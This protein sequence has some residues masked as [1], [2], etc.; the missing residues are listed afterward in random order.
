[1]GSDELASGGA[2]ACIA[3]AVAPS[4][5]RARPLS[6]RAARQTA[7]RGTL[8]IVGVSSTENSGPS[9]IRTFPRNE[10]FSRFCE[11]KIQF[12]FCTEHP[13]HFLT[14]RQTLRLSRIESTRLHERR[15]TLRFFRGDTNH[16]DADGVAR[17]S[18]TMASLSMSAAS[19]S[20][21]ANVADAQR[22]PRVG[23]C[24]RL[25]GDGIPR[26]AFGCTPDECTA[27]TFHPAK[28]RRLVPPR[29]PLSPAPKVNAVVPRQALQTEAIG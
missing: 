14:K 11:P 8:G 3:G 1:M 24:T 16:S 21:G 15:A 6:S 19:L 20:F 22:T 17:S 18:K 7:C 5:A 2:A 29:L 27:W 25:N 4:M 9:L 10:R 23:A 26:E 12:G 13:V 28:T